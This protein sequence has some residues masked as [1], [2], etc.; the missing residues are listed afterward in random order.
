MAYTSEILEA[1]TQAVLL[2]PSAEKAVAEILSRLDGETIE[3]DIL[4]E[5][6]A[7]E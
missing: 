4:E 7:E 3:D 6:Y 1:I 2:G 5:E